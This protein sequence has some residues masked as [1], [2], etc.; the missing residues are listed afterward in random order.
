[1]FAWYSNGSSDRRMP[2]PLSDYGFGWLT[3]R[4]V[5]CEGQ[6]YANIVPLSKNTR[7]L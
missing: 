2:F 4:S 1:M 7:L 6:N 5:T 3:E